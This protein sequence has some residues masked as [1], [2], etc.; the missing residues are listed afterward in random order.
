MVDALTDHFLD[1]MDA[2]ADKLRN[3]HPDKLNGLCDLT[4]DLVHVTTAQARHGVTV[5]ECAHY[6]ELQ[7]ANIRLSKMYEPKTLKLLGVS[8]PITVIKSAV[9]GVGALTLWPMIGFLI[10]KWRGWL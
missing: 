6:R 7:D 8:I 9:T 4:A 1:S 3:G 2:K 5:Q 10:A